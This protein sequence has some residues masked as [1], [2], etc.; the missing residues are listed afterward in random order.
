MC[1][2]VVE[3]A[4]HVVKSSYWKEKKKKSFSILK[5][6]QLTHRLLQP[7]AGNVIGQTDISLT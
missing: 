3:T 5:Y 4:A 6:Y 1:P 2:D 7:S